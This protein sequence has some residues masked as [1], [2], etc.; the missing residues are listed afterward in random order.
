MKKIATVFLAALV[1]AFV[2]NACKSS[3]HCPAYGQ[4]DPPQTTQHG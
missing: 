2:L 4:V 3:E 1:L